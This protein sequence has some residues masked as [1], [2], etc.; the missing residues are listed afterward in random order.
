[1]GTPCPGMMSDSD[2]SDSTRRPRRT[3]E[4]LHRADGPAHHKAPS[5]WPRP[6]STR[7]RTPTPIAMAKSIVSSQTEQITR[8]RTCSRP[9]KTRR[10][11]RQAPPFLPRPTT[12]PT[13]PFPLDPRSGHPTFRPAGHPPSW[14]LPVPQQHPQTPTT[15]APGRAAKPSPPNGR[16]SPD[17]QPH[18][19]RDDHCRYS[20]ALRPLPT[21]ATAPATPVRSL[22]SRVSPRSRSRWPRPRWRCSPLPQRCPRRQRPAPRQS[23]PVSLLPPPSRASPASGLALAVDRDGYTITK[24]APKPVITKTA[25]ASQARQRGAH[26]PRRQ[27]S[28]PRPRAARL[29]TPAPAT[30]AGPSPDTITVSSPFGPRSA[31]CATCSSIH[32][33]ADLTPG[34]APPS[35]LSLP[36]LSECRQRTPSTGSTSSS[37]IR[38]TVGLCPPCTR[39]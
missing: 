28:V 14:S 15:P 33:G 26:R 18:P 17:R 11:S 27:Q 12:G 9:S 6:K 4:A 39:T 32:Q 5:T 35:E 19:N 1:M 29:S 22:R 37:T 2:M 16:R 36:V 20:A 10:G 34:A 3:R 24:P 25:P 30:S 21:V 13:L 38:S 8:C 7:A 31:P 23:C